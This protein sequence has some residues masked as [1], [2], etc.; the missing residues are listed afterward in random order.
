MTSEEKTAF[1]FEE[2]QIAGQAVEKA[3]NNF[4]YASKDL[5]MPDEYLGNYEIAKLDAEDAY[6]EAYRKYEESK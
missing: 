2:L 1:L 6:T 4:F 5:T 3:S